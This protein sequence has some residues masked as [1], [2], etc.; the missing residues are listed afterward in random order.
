MDL[1][2]AQMLM[3]MSCVFDTLGQKPNSHLTLHNCKRDLI[4]SHD[5]KGNHMEFGGLELFLDDQMISYTRNLRRQITRPR[6]YEG[7]PVV[8][9]EYPWEAGHACIYGSVLYDDKKN[10]FRMWY[11]AYG[12]DYY[13]QQ[14]LAY[15]ESPDGITWT[16]LANRAGVVTATILAPAPRTRRLAWLN[17]GLTWIGVCWTGVADWWLAG[18]V[19]AWLLSSDPGWVPGGSHRHDRPGPAW[20]FYDDHCGL[21]HRCVR[22]VLA[23]DRRED[24]IRLAPLQ[25]AAFSEMVEESVRERLPDSIVLV[26]PTGRVLCRSAAIL[27]LGRLLGGCWRLAAGFARLIPRPLADLAYR[28]VAAIRHRL[29]GRPTE[30]CPLIPAELRERF[31]LRYDE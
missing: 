29:F 6:L 23:E 24:T 13:N 8:R 21:C 31:D 5:R 27:E 2:T 19:P 11:N 15:A 22:L 14:V 17:V 30:A 9:R 10:L 7:N 1:S 26:T 12:E 18:L 20:L 16:D 4:S 25:G 3:V 28:L